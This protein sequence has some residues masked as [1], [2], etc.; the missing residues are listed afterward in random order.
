MKGHLVSLGILLSLIAMMTSCKQKTT[1]EA[2]PRMVKVAK[3][4]PTESNESLSFS[5]QIKENREINS[6]FKV[7]GQ[8]LKLKVNEGDK[9]SA[10]QVIAE[11]D[12]RDYQ[13]RLDAAKAQYLQAKGEYERYQQLFDKNK[14]PVNTLDRLKAGYLAAK[15]QYDAAENAMKDTRLTAPFSGYV[16]K[17][18]VENYENVGPGQAIVSLID[19]DNLEIRFNIPGSLL[20]TV[21]QA[22]DFYCDFNVNGEKRVAAKLLSVNQKSNETDQYEV[23]VQPKISGHHLKPGMTARITVAA[24][25]DHPQAITIPM[26]A[27]YYANEKPHIWTVDPNALVTKSQAVELGNLLNDGLVEVKKGIAG[28]ELVVTAGVNSLVEN[29]QVKILGL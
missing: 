15:S 3:V 8:L 12:P 5:G 18:H 2:K 22:N 13:I 11:I 27:V 19:L 25:N 29:Q 6:A 23:R 1:V 7:G 26:G 14:L 10:G 4:N 21:Q 9:V 24:T 17:R 16:S 20:A 28:N